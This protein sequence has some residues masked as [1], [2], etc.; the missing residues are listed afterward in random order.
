MRRAVELPY[1]E[2]AFCYNETLRRRARDGATAPTK[3]VDFYFRGG[4]N[5]FGAF[6]KRVRR[7]MHA[8]RSGELHAQI[9]CT[10]HTNMRVGEAGCETQPTSK[11]LMATESACAATPNARPHRLITH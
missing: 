4:I 6:G 3:A 5:I 2:N 7:A 9:T 10:V 8:L 11:E 1:V